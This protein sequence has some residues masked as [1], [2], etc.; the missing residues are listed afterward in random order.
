M[1][2]ADV[3]AAAQLDREPVA[4]GKEHARGVP[5][6][7]GP[8]A[9]QRR[10]G[11]AGAGF[12]EDPGAE[13]GGGAEGAGSEEEG[14]GRG[15][16]GGLEAEEGVGGDGGRDGSGRRRWRGWGEG[17]GGVEEEG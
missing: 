17:E 5:P 10:A 16:R 9:S 4:D 13:K 15:G 8:A 12:G 3:D 14:A 7:L 11:E 6:D 1:Q 2:R